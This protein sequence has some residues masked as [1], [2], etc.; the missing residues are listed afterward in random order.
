MMRSRRSARDI[1]ALLDDDAPEVRAAAAR[2][3]ADLGRYSYRLAR[4]LR[5]EEH[6]H[7][8]AELIDGLR[9]FGGKWGLRGLT[10]MLRREFHTT[11]ARAVSLDLRV[12]AVDA[13]GF[14]EEPEAVESLVEMLESRD[15]ELRVHAARALHYLTNHRIYDELDDWREPNRWR[16]R[17]MVEK[18]RTWLEEHGE[19]TRDEWLAA[20][21][22][23][24]GYD[25]PDMSVQSVWELTLAVLDADPLSY[26]AQRA[27]MEL[28][29]KEPASLQWSRHDASWYWRRHFRRRRKRYGAPAFDATDFFRRAKRLEGWSE[30]DDGD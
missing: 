19:E 6:P 4:R 10:R 28:S 17:K 21:F 7:V 18:W 3:L 26:N 13:L 8:A 30:P 15:P 27:L 11:L 5:R 20:G 24:A 16:R 14:A 29:G 25:V 1:V 23:Q 22:R 2:A 12:F 9:R